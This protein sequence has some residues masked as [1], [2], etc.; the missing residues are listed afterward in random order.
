MRTVMT[1]DTIHNELLQ[2]KK[3]T[4]SRKILGFTKVENTNGS[5]TSNKNLTK[6]M[7]LIRF[8]WNVTFLQ[9]EL[10]NLFSITLPPGHKT[11]KRSRIKLNKKKKPNYIGE[12]KVLCRRWIK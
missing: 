11:T 2:F 6:W 9:K 8:F 12:E 1:I 7:E 4:F 5:Y 10:D 3:K